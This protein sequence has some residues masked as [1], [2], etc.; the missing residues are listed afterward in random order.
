MSF[1]RSPSVIEYYPNNNP[2]EV[3]EMK[4]SN[5]DLARR[6]RMLLHTCPE[7]SGQET[8][9]LNN[10][11]DFLKTF[12]GLEIIRKEG[13]L[14]ALHHE[15]SE[16]PTIAFRGDMDAIPSPD[17]ARH[18]CGHDGH[19][20]ILCGL[21]LE[22]EGVKIGKNI[23]LIFQPAEETGKGAKMICESGALPEKIDRIYG[24][25]NIPGHEKGTLLLRDECFA[26][27]SCGMIVSVKGRPAH[28]AYPGD[29]ANPAEGLSRLV[30]SIPGMIMDILG[31]EDRLLM[32]T[33]VGLN[34]GGENF[35]LSASEGKLCL[36]LRGHRQSDID[37]LRI[38]IETFTK[39]FCREQDMTCCF[40]LRD[41]FPDTTCSP[42]VVSEA[43]KIWEASGMP[44][45]NLAEPMRWSED[46]G[47]YLKK[48]PG[49]FFGVGTGKDAPGLHTENYEFDDSL[50][51]TAVNAIMALACSGHNQ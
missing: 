38:C 14:I 34:L 7:L 18:S 20:A 31:N 10:I 50:I 32:H 8:R 36:T 22:L 51:E 15:G 17:G 12:T 1:T 29:G 11:H 19:S 44:F 30:L 26:C 13:W 4:N 6:M 46:F 48:I 21:G 45:E 28:A 47:W 16:L 24:L 40:E 9:T 41:V 2:L 5:L 37:A 3:N 33:V 43:R 27:A 25:H 39:D 42:H 49:M 35:G 23:C